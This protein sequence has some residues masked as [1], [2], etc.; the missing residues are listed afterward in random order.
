MIP[1]LGLRVLLVASALVEPRR[2][3][4]DDSA[5]RFLESKDPLEREV[6]MR[7]LVLDGDHG[8][9]AFLA[10]LGRP[11]ARLREAGAAGLGA[12]FSESGR[13][14][15]IVATS[16]PEPGVRVAALTSLAM[17][18]SAACFPGLAAGA[19][20]DD[21]SVRRAAALACGSCS[22]S[23]AVSHL[24]RLARDS[25]RD[26][27]RAAYD[28]LFTRS[29][30]EVDEFLRDAFVFA[31][32]DER[33]RIVER[34]ADSRLPGLESFFEN[35]LLRC[36]EPLEIAAAAHGLAKRGVDLSTHAARGLVL[37]CALSGDPAV[38]RRGYLA[39]L[40]RR[41]AFARLL[42]DVLVSGQPLDDDAYS[43]SARLFV[44]L[45]GPEARDPLLAV[46]R[47]DTGA[48][49]R[50][51]AAAIHAL[52]RFRDPTTP[53]EL[54][55]IYA[56]EQPFV[57]RD[58]LLLA[59]EDQPFT[60]G[61][62]SGLIQ[63]LSDPDSSLRIRAFGALLRYGAE[64]D[65]EMTSLLERIRKERD[66]T[67]RGRMARLVAEHAK[68]DGARTF[69]DAWLPRALDSGA[70]GLEAQNALENLP[71][72]AL[73][74]AA[75]RRIVE[76]AKRPLSETLLRLLS[77]LRGDAA[78]RAIAEAIDDAHARGDSARLFDTALV[79]R[80]GGGDRALD[81][82]EKLLDHEDPRLA[83][84]S[85]RTL[86]RHDRPAAL[87]TFERIFP[88][89]EPEL[90][91]ELLAS[92]E[93]SDVE[94]L[95]AF[96]DRLLTT[97]LDVPTRVALLERAGELRLPLRERYLAIL[98]S[99][100]ALEARLRAIDGL[101]AEGDEVARGILVAAF[102]RGVRALDPAAPD[103]ADRVLVVETIARAL[104]RVG[105]IERAQA[106]ADAIFAFDGSAAAPI[107]EFGG[108]F[109]RVGGFASEEILLA[110]LVDLGATARD[111][112]VT[113]SA[114][115]ARIERLVRDKEAA[116]RS[117]DLLLRLAT[118]LDNAGSE[119][120]SA[121]R[122]LLECALRLPP[123]P[124]RR[125]VKAA[126]D[127]AES[128]SRAGDPDAAAKWFRVAARFVDLFAVD[129]ASRSAVV[130]FGPARATTGFEPLRRLRAR[131]EYERARAALARGAFDS[132]RGALLAAA[133][134]A[135]DDAELAID[136]VETG[137][138]TVETPLLARQ[139]ESVVEGLRVQADLLARCAESFS[140]L[141]DAEGVAKVHQRVDA[142]VRCGLSEDVPARR[143]LLARA[144]ARVGDEEIASAE[145]L[146]AIAGDPAI[147]AAADSDPLLAPL[148]PR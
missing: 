21:W 115:D 141:G 69:V 117:D 31:D 42:L 48:T 11:D 52:R 81:S 72:S 86:L 148:L 78:D 147:R 104:A 80:H 77:R 146:R 32:D 91:R 47:G 145:L 62:R 12:A 88:A 60:D 93:S 2:P 118:G 75:A 16:D 73:S 95:V 3:P 82:L 98:Q 74:H 20:D 107:P 26:V 127:L 122:R 101:A 131:G 18:G 71:E 19:A 103:A 59:F 53:A 99:D 40:S 112:R 135:P 5:T 114:L 14:A 34:L 138:G 113:A 111:P 49:L 61:A 65:V 132:A 22:D 142:L 123:E 38:H 83:Q 94:M 102:D 84:E 66:P 43:A 89:L 25:D 70:R 126:I 55:W 67:I 56:P 85:L 97:E 13:D 17:I 33:A 144:R 109:D 87:A 28:A 23:C 140:R 96:F 35:V 125:E 6:A 108:G 90:R 7:E 92:I 106:L 4:S 119:Y 143:V 37:R 100:P 58:P 36:E 136:L 121:R 15:L 54:A 44:D 79:L 68:G 24:R 116:S 63:A 8:T 124:D 64:D 30:P 105:A 29:E 50:A 39:M 10:A 57:L 129:R 27:R 133:A 9:A 134:A 120:A 1:A 128:W 41:D 137:V 51:R 46:A 110:A 76:R 45:S 139:L 130:A